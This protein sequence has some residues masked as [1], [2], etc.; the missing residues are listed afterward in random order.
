MLDRADGQLSLKAVNF[1]KS[2]KVWAT[3]KCRWAPVGKFDKHVVTDLGDGGG[4]SWF[5]ANSGPVGCMCQR[6]P[7]RV[8]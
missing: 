2:S 7:G 4:F 8:A 3:Q 5:M 1:A 6:E